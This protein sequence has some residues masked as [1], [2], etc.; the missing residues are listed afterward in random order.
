MISGVAQS[1]VFCLL[2]FL[3]LSVC[4][5]SVVHFIVWPSIQ[6]FWLPLLLW[7]LQHFLQELLSAYYLYKVFSLQIWQI[8]L[9]LYLI[10]VYHQI[11]FSWASVKKTCFFLTVISNEL[12]PYINIFFTDRSHIYQPFKILILFLCS[13]PIFDFHLY[14]RIRWWSKHLTD[15]LLS[16]N[17]SNLWTVTSQLNFIIFIC[18]VN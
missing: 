14:K 13:F 9:Q 6:I 15:W 3:P 4:L 8:Q 5:F 7:Y 17:S 2:F 16:L 12:V 11:M 1:L 10:R 18:Y